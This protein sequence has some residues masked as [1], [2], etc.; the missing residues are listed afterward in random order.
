[1]PP[2]VPHHASSAGMTSQVSAQ[3]SP[4]QALG[5]PPVMTA[6]QLH[7]NGYLTRLQMSAQGKNQTSTRHCNTW[8]H[9][10]RGSRLIC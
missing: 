8:R 3:N 2:C 4:K 6:I 10:C 9:L 1:M 5:A 7:H